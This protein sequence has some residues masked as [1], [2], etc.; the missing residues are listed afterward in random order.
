MSVYKCTKNH[1]KNSRFLG[2]LTLFWFICTLEREFSG[3]AEWLKAHAWKACIPQKGIGGSNPFSTTKQWSLTA[4]ILFTE[5][6]FKIHFDKLF[7]LGINK[8]R[9]LKNAIALS[10]SLPI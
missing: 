10:L 1:A 6:T 3:V 5:I 8:I 4:T 9:H 2:I 7:G